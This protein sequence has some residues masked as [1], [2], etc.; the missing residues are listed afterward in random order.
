MTMVLNGLSFEAKEIFDEIWELYKEIDYTKFIFVPANGKI[1]DCN[2]FRRLGD[3]IRN[4]Y[5]AYIFIKQAIHNQN[6]IKHY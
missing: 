5:Y 1:F 3:L 6:E 4:I 2:I